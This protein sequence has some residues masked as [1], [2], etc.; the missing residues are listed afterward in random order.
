MTSLFYLIL[1]IVVFAFVWTLIHPKSEIQ[2][3]ES[4]IE[5]NKK[6]IAELDKEREV[7]LQQIQDNESYLKS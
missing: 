6:R 3:L 1:F 5:A 7:R 2:L 4:E